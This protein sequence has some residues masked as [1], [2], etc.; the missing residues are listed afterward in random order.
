[1]TYLMLHELPLR[2]LG[3]SMLQKL[4][5]IWIMITTRSQTM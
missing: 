4:E 2:M 3:K 5:R 1:M